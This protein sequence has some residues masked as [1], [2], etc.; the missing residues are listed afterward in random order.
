MIKKNEIKWEVFSD[1]N[2]I[3][4]ETCERD[5]PRGTSRER[6]EMVQD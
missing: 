2:G 5:H 6:R 1:G 3:K 4:L